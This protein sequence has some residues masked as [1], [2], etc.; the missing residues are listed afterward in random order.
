MNLAISSL[1]RAC[2][3]EGIGSC[4]GWVMEHSQHIMV[5]DLSPD[6]LS[7]MRPTTNA[8]RKEQMLLAKVANGRKSRSGCKRYHKRG[9][10]HGMRNEMHFPGEVAQYR[11]C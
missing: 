3:P 8:P 6:N 10:P 2:T 7:L 9:S 5:L 11:L 1:R 4:V